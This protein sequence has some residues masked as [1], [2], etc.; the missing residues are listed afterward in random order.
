MDK[1]IVFLGDSITDSF[2]KL[3]VDPDQLGNGYVRMAADVLWESGRRDFIRNS[4]HD[5]FTVSGLLRMFEY[6]CLRFDPDIVSV[7][8]G[9]ND[10]AVAM[11]TGKSLEQQNFRENY[12]KLLERICKETRAK[13]LCM[14]PFIFPK[15]LEYAGWIP[16]IR[17]AEEIEEQAARKCGAVFVP[18]HEQLNQEAQKDGYDAITVDGTHLT[19]NGARILARIWM[20]NIRRQGWLR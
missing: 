15:P 9:S 4:G 19:E 12:E 8:I 18:L 14:G 20:E 16:V 11:N 1:C 7:L 10:A 2:H 13:I 6:D 17:K 5:G 3:N